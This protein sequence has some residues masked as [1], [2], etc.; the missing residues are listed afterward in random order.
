[1]ASLLQWFHSGGIV[2]PFKTGLVHGVACLSRQ[3][4]GPTSL[5]LKFSAFLATDY[6]EDEAMALF[7]LHQYNFTG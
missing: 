2:D 5:L 3:R 6:W 7:P 1:M 4:R